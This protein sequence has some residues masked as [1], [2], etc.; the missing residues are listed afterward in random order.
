MM[1]KTALRVKFFTLIGLLSTSLALGASTNLTFG[2]G[3]AQSHLNNQNFGKLSQ[4]VQNL[5]EYSFG[6][7]I[8]PLTRRQMGDLF[9][10]EALE[11]RLYAKIIIN[12]LD[13]FRSRDERLKTRYQ[14][15]RRVLG[16]LWKKSHQDPKLR[17]L[18]L[19]FQSAQ[20]EKKIG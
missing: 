3:H 11:M 17:E 10:C 6:D 20:S 13:L 1:V 18:F 7:Q 4:L 2:K 8:D 12:E 19:L 14:L 16:S 5:L 9:E 15:C